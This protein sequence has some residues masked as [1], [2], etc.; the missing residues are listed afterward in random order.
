MLGNDM[1]KICI[2]HVEL[3]STPTLQCVQNKIRRKKQVFGL[4]KCIYI[5]VCMIMTLR[6]QA[7]KA[8]TCLLS[9]DA[10]YEHRRWKYIAL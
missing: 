4:V 8:T 9:G 6:R 10:F 2:R 3:S 5:H 1:Q 7:K